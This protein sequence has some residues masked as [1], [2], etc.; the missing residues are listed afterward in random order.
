MKSFQTLVGLLLLTGTSVAAGHALTRLSEQGTSAA[1][2][3]SSQ[4]SMGTLP[5]DIYP[6]T[7]N[8]FPAIKREELDEA[9]KKLYD[10]RG[11][12]ADSFGPGAIRIY[13]PPVAETMTS[14]N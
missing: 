2:G 13:S 6:D 9:G 12:G 5:K 4:A 7:G 10:T 11:G 1:A 14:L 3:K 8:R